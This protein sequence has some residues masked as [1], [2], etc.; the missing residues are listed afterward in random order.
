[1]ASPEKY[2]RET[3][4]R[5]AEEGAVKTFEAGVGKRIKRLEDAAKIAYCRGDLVESAR[6][7]ERALSLY[8]KVVEK[9]VARSPIGPI[10]GRFMANRR[11]N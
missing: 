1:L 6:M 9:R 4:G 11:R 3:D 7:E 5:L 2:R 10:P 8:V